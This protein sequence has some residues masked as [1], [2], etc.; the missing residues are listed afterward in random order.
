MDDAGDRP[1]PPEA[2]DDEPTQSAP[3]P[4]PP[5]AARPDP[6]YTPGG[7]PTLD[8]VR[9]KIESR[10]ATALGATELAEESAKGREIEEQLAER[11]EAAKD[12]LE[13]IRKS[14]HPKT[15]DAP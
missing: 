9:D 7:V 12:R 10:Y 5:A 13:Q 6:D 11:D 3:V 2:A 1:D 8:Y 15:D 4:A 14:L